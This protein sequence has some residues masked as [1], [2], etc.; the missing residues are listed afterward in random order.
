MPTKYEIANL[1][2]NKCFWGNTSYTPEYILENIDD[3]HLAKQIFSAVLQ[4]S[5]FM[6]RDLSIIKKEYIVEFLNELRDKDLNH[7]QPFLRLRLDAL[8]NTYIDPTYQL[9]DRKWHI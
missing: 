1:I 5:D 7:K 2:I 8:I 9:R 4:S 3:K 6:A